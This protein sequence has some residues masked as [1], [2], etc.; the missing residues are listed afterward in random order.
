ME[1]GSLKCVRLQLSL[2]KNPTSLLYTGLKDLL[3]AA[4]KPHYS[5]T[6]HL[7]SL[8]FFCLCLSF[9]FLFFLFSP[10]LSSSVRRACGG[11]SSADY[12][13]VLTCKSTPVLVKDGSYSLF[14]LDGR[15]ASAAPCFGL[16]HGY[17][18]SQL[19]LSASWS[20]GNPLSI[21]P[22]PLQDFR[23]EGH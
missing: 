7:I 13:Y 8:F 20:H 16:S 12:M 4:E 11:I 10:P 14:C 5:L 18:V 22:P 2:Q 1:G 23:H 15:R 19:R 6:K 9:S 21:S 17:W 3:T